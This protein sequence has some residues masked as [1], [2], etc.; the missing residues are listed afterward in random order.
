MQSLSTYR[1]WRTRIDLNCA[2]PVS[3]LCKNKIKDREEIHHSSLR[4]D[5]ER[6]ASEMSLFSFPRLQLF[7]CLVVSALGLTQRVGCIQ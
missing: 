6:K 4:G 7:F 1:I 5:G 2:A 3:S